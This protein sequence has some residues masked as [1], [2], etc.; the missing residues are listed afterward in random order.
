MAVRDPAGFD[1]IPEH[2]KKRCDFVEANDYIVTA[3]AQM[4]IEST[5]TRLEPSR[6]GK[7]RPVERVELT[8][9]DLS[10]MKRE[11][12]WFVAKAFVPNVENKPCLVYLDG[13][14]LNADSSNLAWM[15]V[16]EARAHA[17]LLGGSSIKLDK[18]T[19]KEIHLANKYNV[20]TASIGR[21]LNI[22]EAEVKRVLTGKKDIDL[23]IVNN[24]VDWQTD[25]HRELVIDLL[26]SGCSMATVRERIRKLDPSFLVS[27]VYNIVNGMARQYLEMDE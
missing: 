19:I 15:D 1:R 26:R 20:S 21:K 17:K 22:P 6:Y 24:G 4:W 12:G 8:R 2:M 18:D 23:P 9:D 7:I 13:N 14:T 5:K 16:W 10:R 3:N 25:P 11:I 27:R